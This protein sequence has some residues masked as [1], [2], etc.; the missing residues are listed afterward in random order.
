MAKYVE[1][2]QG[3]VERFEMTIKTMVKENKERARITADPY[4]STNK[5]KTIITYLRDP[6]QQ[7]KITGLFCFK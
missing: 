6:S 2:E 3:N 4:Q 5:L 7:C 1:D